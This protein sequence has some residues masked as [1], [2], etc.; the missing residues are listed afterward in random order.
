MGSATPWGKCAVIRLELWCCMGKCAVMRLELWCC[1]GKCA[2]TRLELHSD[3]MFCIYFAFVLH[4]YAVDALR[5]WLRPAW[6]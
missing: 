2:V 6:W 4:L 3:P 5:T 1:M